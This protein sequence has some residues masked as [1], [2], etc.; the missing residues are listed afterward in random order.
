MAI[1]A[2]RFK[3]PFGVGAVAGATFALFFGRFVFYISLALVTFIPA[4]AALILAP[5]Y[6]QAIYGGLNS[7]TTSTLIAVVVA[8]FCGSLLAALATYAVVMEVKGER[9]GFGQTIAAAGPRIG[10]VIVASILVA[11]VIGFCTLLLIIPGLIA[12]TILWVVIPIVVV[13]RIGPFASINRSAALTKGYRW[14]IFGVIIIFT[15]INIIV[16]LFMQFAIAPM[17]LNSNMPDVFFW[18]ALAVDVVFQTLFATAAAY[19]YFHLKVVKEGAQ[20]DELA[21]VFA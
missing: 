18:I 8:M 2:D 4:I 19:S 10:A 13:E 9:V 11:I 5:G 20:I 21:S 1:D 12:T 3:R 7:G 17:L 15:V 16:E 6:G 14:S